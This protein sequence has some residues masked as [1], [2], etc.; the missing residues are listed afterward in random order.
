MLTNKI[1]KKLQ[2]FTKSIEDY[3]IVALLGSVIVLSI[4]QIGMRLFFNSSLIWADELVKILV[5]WIALVA[6][7]SASRSDRHLKIDI[8]DKLG[9]KKNIIFPKTVVTIFVFIVCALITWHSFRYI[10]LI[11]DFE[12]SILNGFPAWIA[13]SVV[14]VSFFIMAYRY[15]I[16]SI[17]NTIKILK[18]GIN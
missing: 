15:L 11:Y 5:L 17:K 3:V 13:Y 16:I 14:P 6:A 4:T 7:V 18:E 12:E 10:K 8:L 1:K 2:T 9:F